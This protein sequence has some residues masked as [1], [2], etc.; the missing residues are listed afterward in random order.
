MLI[1][2]SRATACCGSRR[3]GRAP[4]G[5]A[6][7]ARSHLS[8]DSVRAASPVRMR[9]LSARRHRALRAH[10]RARWTRPGAYGAQGDRHGADREPRG[11]LLQRRGVARS[12]SCY[13]RLEDALR[14]SV[15]WRGS[16]SEYRARR[17]A[18]SSSCGGIAALSARSGAGAEPRSPSSPSA[19]RSRRKLSRGSRS[20]GHR[21]FGENYDAGSC[22]GRACSRGRAA[23]AS[24]GTSSATYQR[25]RVQSTYMPWLHAVHSVDSAAA[26]PRSLSRQWGQRHR[27][28]PASRSPASSPESILERENAQD[29]ASRRRSTPALAGLARRG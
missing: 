23:R 4:R 25:N 1:P 15:C 14:D 29:T 12:A 27:P 9:K 8:R 18:T 20:L 17:P 6:A 21:D 19:N 11:Q 26:W 3:A 5:G 22:G 7:A 10:R 24:A 13:S 16:R 28:P 2:C